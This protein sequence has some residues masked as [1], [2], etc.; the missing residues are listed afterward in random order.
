MWENPDAVC[1]VDFVFIVDIVRNLSSRP[2]K[3]MTV[4][5]SHKVH[6]VRKVHKVVGDITRNVNRNRSVTDRKRRTQRIT[7][8][9]PD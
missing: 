7:P 4:I 1:F 5:G 9:A 6:K 2:S 3:R 8:G